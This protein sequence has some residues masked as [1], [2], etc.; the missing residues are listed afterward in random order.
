MKEARG[1][2]K[3]SYYIGQLFLNAIFIQW[4][5]L[6][7]TL[8]GLVVMG[9]FPALLSSFQ[10]VNKL[11]E[12]DDN[13]KYHD[14]SQLFKQYYQDNFKNTNFTGYIMLILGL[15]LLIDLNVSK[16]YIQSFFLHIVLI[17]FLVL[18]LG[19]VLFLFPVMA[20]YQLSVKQNIKQACLTFLMNPIEAVAICLG[21]LILP[22][23][24]VFFPI[25]LIFS[26]FP[27]VIFIILFFA[28]QGIKKCEEKVEKY[29]TV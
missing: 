23:I 11:R 28:N 25:F 20:R 22:L 26:S 10:L 1:I 17:I 6:I 2:V 4:F 8:K 18:Y 12:T 24:W 5:L 27:I 14:M 16:L 7:Y 19:T 21:L 15:F 29:E 9:F 3:W 13:L